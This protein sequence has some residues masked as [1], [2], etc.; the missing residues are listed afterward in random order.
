[1]SHLTGRGD[2]RLGQ[3]R[4]ASHRGK[5]WGQVSLPGSAQ[6]DLG[7]NSWFLLI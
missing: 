1:M 4:P 7:V 5:A 3:G 2:P 6:L